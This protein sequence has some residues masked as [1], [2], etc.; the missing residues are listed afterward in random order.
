MIFGRDSSGIQSEITTVNPIHP[1]GVAK[2]YADN[3][4]REFR[5]VFGMYCCS[6]IF[7]NHESER[8]GEMFFSKKITTAVAD[9]MKGGKKKIKVGSLDSVRD[10]GYAPDYMQ[11]VYLM[12]NNSKPT[13]YVIG[14]G[15]L[16]SLLDF[17]ERCFK[18]AGLESKRHIEYDE[19]LYRKNDTNVLCADASKIKSELGWQPTMPTNEMIQRMIEYNLQETKFANTY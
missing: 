15:K 16:I 6:G 17:I 18:Y 14:T 19:S 11:A 10:Y 9:I 3:M 5:S 12:M 2:A 13:D 7:F 1:Y 4:V 8:R